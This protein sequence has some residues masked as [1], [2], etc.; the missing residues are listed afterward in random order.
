MAKDLGGGKTLSL[1]VAADGFAHSV[2]AP[3]GCAGCHA[4]IQLDKHP[5]QG[6]DIKDA[7]KYSVAMVA[8]CRNCH[9]EVFTKSEGSVHALV[10]AAG[11]DAAPVC[12]DCHGSH[13]VTRKTAYETCIGCHSTAIEA[14][15]KWLT[16]APLHMEVVSCAACHAPGA[17][18]I[19]DLRFFDKATGKWLV[20]P[21]A[22]PDFEKLARS[23]DK[24]GKGLDAKEL[25][26]MI[27]Q[28]N[29][30]GKSG[31]TLRGR[32]ELAANAE[33]H[34]L[35]GH[36]KAIRE[37]ASCHRHGA[38]PFKTVSVSMLSADGR[39]LRYKVKDEVLGSVLLVD[40][41]GD[42]Y[43]IGGTRNIVLD[44]LLVLAFLGGLAVP[45]GHQTLKWFVR[46]QAKADEKNDSGND[47]APGDGNPS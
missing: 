41:L 26:D 30:E 36:T 18:R 34:G 46:R 27:A 33:A 29:G 4:D 5:A 14:H 24:D 21:D 16:N 39:A 13:A 47:A 40:A 8:A 28:V 23:F 1:K 10:Q 44:G 45:V 2:H 19:V 35:A 6:Q 42:F 11:A 17:T 3:V 20:E 12:T 37:C 32:I 22:V 31:K 9:E 43:A 15:G 38:E 7:R 25:R